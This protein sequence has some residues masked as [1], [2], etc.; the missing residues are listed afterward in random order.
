LTVFVYND[1][2]G[3][4][5]ID[6]VFSAPEFTVMPYDTFGTAPG[7]SVP[8]KVVFAPASDSIYA[9]SLVFFSNDTLSSP[10]VVHVN[11]VGL[12]EGQPK[13]RIEPT[14]LNF[15]TVFVGWY[16]TLHVFVYNDS[17]G[18]LDIDSV[19]YPSEITV[20]PVDTSGVD[21]GD[22][23]EFEIVFSPDTSGGYFDSVLFF[24]NDT[25]RSPSSLLIYAYGKNALGELDDDAP[26]ILG[27]GGV[28]INESITQDFNIFNV[29]ED[30]LYVD[31]LRMKVGEAYTVFDTAGKLFTLNDT[32]KVQVTFS[33]DSINKV[34]DDSVMVYFR[35]NFTAPD[36]KV[37]YR[38]EGS[39]MDTVGRMKFYP[40]DSIEFAE[41]LVNSSDSIFIRIDNGGGDTL[42]IDS[43]RIVNG[44]GGVFEFMASTNTELDTIFNTSDTLSDSLIFGV[45]FLPDSG[46]TYNDLLV[47]FYHRSANLPQVTDTLSVS[48][49]GKG[50]MMIISPHPVANFASVVPL[51]MSDTMGIVIENPGADTTYIDS[52]RFISTMTISG[53]DNNFIIPDSSKAL[54]HSD[55]LV[56]DLIFQPSSTGIFSD[57]LLI[58]GNYSVGGAVVE[59]LFVSGNS[60]AANIVTSFDSINVGIV[61]IGT[62]AHNVLRIFNIGND[63][64]H[65][66]E[67]KFL[68]TD[69][70]VLKLN[71][72]SIMLNYPDSVDIDVAFSPDSIGLFEDTL[73]IISN[74]P[75]EPVKY[76]TFRGGG[77][78]YIY[79][80][81][82]ED[83]SV[84]SYDASLILQRVVNLVGFSLYQDSAADVSG[85]GFVGSFDASLV[86]QYTAGFLM[87]FPV[88]QGLMFKTP[89]ENIEAVIRNDTQKAQESKQVAF[90]LIAG[91]AGEVYSS[92]GII[93]YD[94]SLLKFRE[95]VTESNIL[96][97]T[98]DQTGILKFAIASPVNLSGRERL[99][100]FVFDILKKSGKQSKIVVDKLLLNETAVEVDEIVFETG[101][102]IPEDYFMD[103]NYPNPFNPET[104]IRY[105]IPENGKVVIKIFNILG[106]EIKTLVDRE[107]KAGYYE[108]KW[109]GLNKN[110]QRV[111]SGVYIYVIKVNSFIK[112]K[113]MVFLK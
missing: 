75:D 102:M 94:P 79:G 98:S 44:Y 82:S 12:F 3:P 66:S 31:S 14:S 90:S 80:D 110:N 7:D 95:L 69:T 27:F 42:F 107:Q 18:P 109:R 10:F 89:S 59:T 85:N 74:D 28:R 81:P 15:D 86:L 83:G 47:V 38:V 64:L 8:V 39:G 55:S 23:I 4:L 19:F 101:K 48:G 111:G 103:Q 77:A 43:M 97:T 21:S 68:Y 58:Y 30:T 112:I 72:D 25:L 22:S 16:D 24:S 17:G 92:E 49:V 52:M 76:I 70:S 56:F 60:A 54:L 26:A 93:R 13:I 113:R 87:Q 29:G 96:I 62:T 51:G 99:V 88:G 67:I 36:S 9:D 34:Y 78:H 63:S 35:P 40:A 84:S 108:V 73:R 71:V 57:T 105:G 61:R 46:K 33:P 104:T 100:T 2:G 53:I 11:G 1:S 50:P 91:N 41:T 37:F 5:N 6:S 32:I 20:M 45:A 65:I 106:Q